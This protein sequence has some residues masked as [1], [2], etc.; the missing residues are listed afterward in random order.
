MLEYINGEIGII[1]IIILYKNNK[2]IFIKKPIMYIEE[3]TF[4]LLNWVMAIEIGPIQITK[5]WPKINM[6]KDIKISLLRGRLNHLMINLW[7][8]KINKTIKT[9]SKSEIFKILKYSLLYSP[10]K[11]FP[12]LLKD[13]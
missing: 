4:C 11:L 7:K 1:L 12:L 10:S 6:I 5:N 13:E 3:N 9:E 8:D 2:I